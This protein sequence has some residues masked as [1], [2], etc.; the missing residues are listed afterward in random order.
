MRKGVAVVCGMITYKLINKLAKKK[1][2][3]WWVC[4]ALV[5]QLMAA[6]NTL[7]CELQMEDN[8]V[9]INFIWLPREN[10]DILL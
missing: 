10:F 3:Q 9:F 5:C 8:E 7:L 2:R 4:E 6:S 1:K